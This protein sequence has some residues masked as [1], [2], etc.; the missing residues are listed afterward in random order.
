[1]ETT[2]LDLSHLKI[3]REM[4]D[5][6]RS[7]YPS[8]LV[9]ASTLEEINKCIESGH[10]FGIFEAKKLVS[11][12]LCYEDEYKFSAFIEKT[13]TIV[14]HRG[15]GYNS[16]LMKRVLKSIKSARMSFAVAMVSPSNVNSVEAFKSAGFTQHKKLEYQNEARLL[17]TKQLLW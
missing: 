8:S 7:V 5:T 10:S 15:K 6:L 3:V 17:M 16:I 2:R 14:G 9:I 12:V 4:E 11:Y 1:M 13:N